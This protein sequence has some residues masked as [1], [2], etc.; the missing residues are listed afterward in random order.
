MK[1]ANEFES[2]AN[3]VTE[4]TWAMPETP[5]QIK[6]L[7]ELMQ[8][9]LPVGPDATNAT[10]LLY[11]IVGDD[12][13][14][15]RLEELAEQDPD[16]DARPIIQRRLDQLGID[17]GLDMAQEDLDT[18]GVMMTKPSNMSSESVERILK[19]AQLLK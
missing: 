14:F 8:T 4:G 6:R 3:Q 1:E 7:R 15:D 10:E 5:E 13:L 9:E 11:D 2:W 12:E 16:A 18:D 19:L 17:L